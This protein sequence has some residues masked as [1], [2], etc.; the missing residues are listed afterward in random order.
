ML[1]LIFLKVFFG[2]CASL[3]E[4]NFVSALGL[5]A[6]VCSTSVAA[7]RRRWNGQ[8]RF[9]PIVGV[10]DLGFMVQGKEKKG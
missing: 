1:P 4:A 7:G 9:N 8:T 2:A 10:L 3:P 5:S 6:S